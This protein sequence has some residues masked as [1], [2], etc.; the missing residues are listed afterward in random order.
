[1]FEQRNFRKGRKGR[2][3]PCTHLAEAE[4]RQTSERAEAAQ[5][6]EHDQDYDDEDTFSC[7]TAKTQP[8]PEFRWNCKRYKVVFPSCNKLFMH[9]QTG[10]TTIDTL[11]IHADAATRAAIRASA[12]TTAEPAPNPPASH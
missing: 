9:Q 12:S 10:F 5:D 11:D 8:S 2:L 3:A 7:M 1:M 6:T 4:R